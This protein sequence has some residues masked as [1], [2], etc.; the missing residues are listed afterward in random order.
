M[1]DKKIIFTKFPETQENFRFILE[2]AEN[3]GKTIFAPGER[4]RLKLY[5]GG[6][7]PELSVTNGTAKT[8]LTGLT[9][10]YTEFIAYKDSDSASVSFYI[11]KLISTRWEG[12]GAGKPS[13][14]GSRLILPEPVTG[15]LRVEYQTSFDLIDVVCKEPTYV[16]VTASDS[17]FDGDF[18]IDFTEGYQTG[19]YEKDVVLT[20]RDACTRETLPDAA[21]YIN[22]KYSGKSDSIGV[23][24]LGSMKPGTYALKIVKEGYKATDQDNIRNDFFTVE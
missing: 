8:Y 2:P 17:S 16:L 19:I 3:A 12:Q 21:V 9:R 11:D 10:I 18:L 23:V 5:P 4:A 20:I 7:K 22:E 14:S 24:R 13:V 15:V 1:N 6:R